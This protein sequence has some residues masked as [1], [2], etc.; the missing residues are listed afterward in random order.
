MSLD[1]LVLRA[2]SSARRFRALRNVV[3]TAMLSTDTQVMLAWF[4]AYYG[5]FPTREEVIVDELESLVRLR[6]AAASPEQIALTLHMCKQLRMPVDEV[7][8]QGILGQLHELDLSGRAGALI[9]R[10]NNGEEINLAHELNRLSQE[11][12]RSLS[13]STPEDYCDTPID[14]ILSEI[15][16]DS[17]IKFRR[18]ALLREGIAGLQGGA[19]LAIGARPDKGK[20]SFI[21]STLTDFAPQIPHVFGDNRPILWLNNEGSS[22]RIKPRLYQ[23]ALGLD[24]P[25]IIALS[26]KGELVKRYC[27]A[28]QNDADFIRVKDAHSMSMAQVEQVVESVRPSV[29]VFDMLANMRLSKS[30]AGGNKAD[31]VEQLWQQARELAVRY[32]FIAMSTIQISADGDNQ[33]YPSYSHLTDSKT[34]VQGATD[35]IIMLGSLN[36]PDAQSLRGLSTPKNKFAVSGKPSCVMG[37][38]YFDGARC[39]FS[40]GSV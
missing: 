29:V 14:E 4:E 36:N 33:L 34:G 20:T 38:L 3:P 32:D 19:S 7:A 28:I 5:A 31:A 2:L 27:E 26:N 8:V 39:T 10:Y 12:V 15:E 23:G 25:G 24:L 9:S 35:V 11:A 22:K 18:I 37:E 21:A 16:D 13:Q 6:S 17:G 30:E 40:D 1:I